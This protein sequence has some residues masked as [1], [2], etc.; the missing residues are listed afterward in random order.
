MCRYAICIF[1]ASVFGQ[2]RTWGNLTRQQLTK[3][4]KCKLSATYCHYT[5]QVQIRLP[6]KMEQGNNV[7]PWSHISC[8]KLFL[9]RRRLNFW[10]FSASCC[11]VA[12]RSQNIFSGMWIW[13]RHQFLC[14]T[15][16]HTV[17]GVS[18]GSQNSASGSLPPPSLKEPGVWWAWGHCY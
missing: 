2:V 3:I 5:S 13:A 6:T 8:V 7:I 14:Y 16:P 17:T 10:Y 11:R 18:T 1:D 12:F 4:L 9:H 15:S